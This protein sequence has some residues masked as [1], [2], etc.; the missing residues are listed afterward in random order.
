M[1]LGRDSPGV[2]NTI[3]SPAAHVCAQAHALG[4]AHRRCL[5][6][7]P[8]TECFH[9]VAI[10]I[11]SEARPFVVPAHRIFKLQR[12]EPGGLAMLPSAQACWAAPLRCPAVLQRSWLLADSAHACRALLCW[13]DG[14]QCLP[15]AGS[16]ANHANHWPA[17]PRSDCSQ[18][19]PNESTGT[20]HEHLD[21]AGP[22]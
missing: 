14:A 21:G 5:R 7:M 18:G 20:P 1:L 16:V 11:A 15:G 19:L 12:T 22:D 6:V 9:G 10:L 8:C 2:C 4:W 17:E 13:A 3:D